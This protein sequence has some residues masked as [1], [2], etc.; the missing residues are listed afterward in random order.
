[1]KLVDSFNLSNMNTM[2]CFNN[3]AHVLVIYSGELKE[4]A[5]LCDYLSDFLFDSE[6]ENSVG[7]YLEKLYNDIATVSAIWLWLFKILN[8]FCT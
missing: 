4:K 1:M 6:T 5:K 7:N 8:H 2:A 3:N